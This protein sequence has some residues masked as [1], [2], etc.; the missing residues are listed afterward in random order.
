MRP[1][2]ITMTIPVEQARALLEAASRGLD[3]WDMSPDDATTPDVTVQALAL[4][5]FRRVTNA[6][7]S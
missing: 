5:G 2:T 7:P 4:R 6:L 3:E 1:T